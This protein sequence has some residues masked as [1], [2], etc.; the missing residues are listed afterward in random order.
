[1][2][3][4]IFSEDFEEIEYCDYRDICLLVAYSDLIFDIIDKGRNREELNQLRLSKHELYML[5]ALSE[6]IMS[7]E[8]EVSL[9]ET[10]FKLD[11][12]LEE[13]TE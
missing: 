12:F 5:A 3:E 9:T 6:A 8:S 13:I 1:M 10:R 2:L 11:S 4:R 7:I